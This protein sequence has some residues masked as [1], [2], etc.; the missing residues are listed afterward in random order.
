MDNAHSFC[1]VCRSDF[2][3]GHGGKM[4]VTQHIKSQWHNRN[5]YVHSMSMWNRTVKKCYQ[6]L[7]KD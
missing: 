6:I 4:Y 2:N 7:G 3:I 5:R 1:K